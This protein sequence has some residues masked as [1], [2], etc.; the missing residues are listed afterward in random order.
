MATYCMSRE[1]TSTSKILNMTR[2]N[3]LQ[4]TFCSAY[5]ETESSSGAKLQQ[6]LQNNVY[7][8]LVWQ[9]FAHPWFLSH[10]VYSHIAVYFKIYLNTALRKC[11][12][13]SIY[14][15]HLKSA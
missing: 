15:S 1:T 10:N 13:G 2:Q 12:D 7:N 11:L 4:N 6:G 3:A 8:G 9:I 5:N 14:V